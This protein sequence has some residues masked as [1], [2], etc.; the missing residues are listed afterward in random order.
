MQI[1]F[2]NHDLVAAEELRSKNLLKN[3]ALAQSIQD[4]GWRS[5]FSKLEYKVKLYG[6][7]YTKAIQL[8]S[9]EPVY[10]NDRGSVLYMMKDYTHAIEEYTKAIKLNPDEA[11]IYYNR[12]LVY[13]EVDESDKAIADFSKTIELDPNSAL[14]YC[15]RGIVYLLNFKDGSKAIIDI[16]K[17]IA[18]DP[19]YG[20][21]YLARA[22]YYYELGDMENSNADFA[23]AKMLSY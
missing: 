10:Y 21:A 13:K 12:G 8:N 18:L 7:I 16:N 2:K 5:F 20:K 14:A 23:K 6:K 22:L 1:H 9:N 3:R 19:R 4:V 17:S 11:L 15:E